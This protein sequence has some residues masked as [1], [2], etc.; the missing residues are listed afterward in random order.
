MGFYTTVFSDVHI[1]TDK[2]EEFRKEVNRMRSAIEEADKYGKECS[3]DWFGY[4]WDVSVNEDGYIDFYE[5]YRKWYEEDKFYN[6]LLQFKPRGSFILVG[7]S[8]DVSVVIFKD[9][10]WK[11]YDVYDAVRCIEKHE[12]EFKPIMSS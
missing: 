10:K 6:W 3:D 12:D 1:D 7:E 9:G 8:M 11:L 4:Y 5:T 2:I